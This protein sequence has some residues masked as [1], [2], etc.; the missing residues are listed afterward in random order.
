MA[1]IQFFF[2]K[3]AAIHHLGFVIH[4]FGPP[5][6]HRAKFGWNQC[7]SFNHM[8]VL[9]F[10]GLGFLPPKCFVGEFTPNIGKSVNTTSKALAC[11]ETRHTMR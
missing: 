5:K 4:V 11:A 8:E 9:I 10:Y 1:T 3:M 6:S 2:S 7:S